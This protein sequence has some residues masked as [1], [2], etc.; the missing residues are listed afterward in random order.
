MMYSGGVHQVFEELREKNKLTDFV[1]VMPSDGLQG[2]GTGYVRHTE[3]NFE[4]WVMEDVIDA[5][6]SA[7][8]QVTEDSRI[9]LCGLSMGGYG[10][11]RLGTK[12]ASRISGI[13]AH[14]SVTRYE[15]LRLF[16]KSRKGDLGIAAHSDNAILHWAET[17]RDILPPIRFDCGLEDPLLNHNRELQKQLEDLDVPHK[18][19]EHPGGHDWDY[20]H[21]QV[22]SSLQFFHSIENQNSS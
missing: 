4:H 1:L 20:W 7:L 8:P 11:L 10:A 15:D 13:S 2:Q 14:S 5:T 22:S 3:A 6:Q 18:Y 21:R 12:Y 9:Y 16:I 19:E 17:N